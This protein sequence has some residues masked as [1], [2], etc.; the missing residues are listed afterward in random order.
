MVSTSMFYET[1]CPLGWLISWVT[2]ASPGVQS[3]IIQDVSVQM[4]LGETN[5]EIGKLRKADEP[6]Q[7]EWVLS[8]LL[9]T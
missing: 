1:S 2:L 6:P 8:N 5:I 7:G 9:K 3:N 4:C